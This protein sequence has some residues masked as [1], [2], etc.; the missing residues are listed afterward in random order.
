MFF[1]LFKTVE[2]EPA[3]AACVRNCQILRL[4]TAGSILFILKIWP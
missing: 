4:Q 1:G 2:S 3:E